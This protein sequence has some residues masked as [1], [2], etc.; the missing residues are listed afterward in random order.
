MADELRLAIDT[1]AGRIALTAGRP[2]VGGVYALTVVT[3]GQNDTSRLVRFYRIDQARGIRWPLAEAKGGQ[4]LALDS[5]D[6][7]KAWT[8]VA[9]SRTMPCEVFAYADDA[10]VAHGFVTVEWSPTLTTV[11]GTPIDV[12]GPQGDKGE[13]G[14]KGDKGDPGK[15]AYDGAIEHGYD[16]T[17]AEFYGLLGGVDDLV[18]AAATSAR[19]AATSAETAA[20]E[21]LVGAEQLTKAVQAKE[22][23]EDA[24]RRAEEAASG[25][26]EASAAAEAAKEAAAT[27]KAAAEKIGDVG[28][29]IDDHNNPH[30]VTAEQVGALTEEAADAKYL[31]VVQDVMNPQNIT[32]AL[33]VCGVHFQ[34]SGNVYTGGQLSEGGKWLQRI[35]AKKDDTEN[36]LDALE[37]Q[38]GDLLYKAIAFTSG[39]VSPSVAEVGATVTSVLL[40]WALNKEPKSLTL[41]G[42][43]LGVTET[44]KTVTGSWTA[45]KTWVLK[46]T[47]ERGATATRNLTLAFQNKAYW[48]VGTATGTAIDDAF[49]LG[50]SGSAF[51]TGR[52]RTF[53]ANAGAGQFIYYVFPKSWGTP[54]FKVGGFEGGFALDREWE[55]TNAS[56]GKVQY[57]A[58]RSTNAALGQ[59]TVVVS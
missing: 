25:T 34:G 50:L 40:K 58:W 11:D 17:E 22:D 48:G 24:A 1:R 29:H 45:A 53:S 20:A 26:A 8:T 28:D 46:A 51:A 44:Q 54:V 21:T 57:Q 59:T 4:E 52:G 18:E 42:T 36:R 13:K 37:E 16:G 49:V 30:E 6:F 12:R 33:K 32:G 47:D 10:I 27:A 41:D 3:D 39:S 9:P 2:F 23:A 55:H 38:M 56:G 7:R 43:A 19:A 14:D 15:S 5:A 35:Y 31:K